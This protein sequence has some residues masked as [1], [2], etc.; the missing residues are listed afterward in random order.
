MRCTPIE[1]SPR[2]DRKRFGPSRHVTMKIYLGIPVVV[3]A[4]ARARLIAALPEGIHEEESREGKRAVAHV[5][6]TAKHPVDQR[7]QPDDVQP[8]KHG[9]TGYC[10]EGES[11]QRHVREA[12]EWARLCRVQ[13]RGRGRSCTIETNVQWAVT[14]RNESPPSFG[15]AD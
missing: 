10:R 3:V 7:R 13:E 4:Q 2:C 1:C 9:Y 12:Q 6:A 15:G 5:D 14:R 11:L 8:I